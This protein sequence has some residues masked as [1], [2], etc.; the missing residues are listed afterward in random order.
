MT[1]TPALLIPGPTS[2]HLVGQ[3]STI[4]LDHEQASE[5]TGVKLES[6]PDFGW[7]AG[8]YV[9]AETQNQNGHLFHL[10]DVRDRHEQV[11]H[12]A[13]NM[14]HRVHHVLGTFVSSR[15]ILPEGVHAAEALTMPHTQTVAAFWRRR[16]PD[17]W[18]DVME[19]HAQGMAWLSMEAIPESL[20]CVDCNETF[21]YKGPVHESYCDVLRDSIIAP[22][23][24]N[25]P[26]FIGGAAVIP[27]A[28]PGW[29]SADVTHVAAACLAATES[30]AMWKAVTDAA[31]NLGPAELESLMAMLQ[32]L[33]V[34][35]AEAKKR[36]KKWGYG[37]MGDAKVSKKEANYRPS[38]GD[39]QCGNCAHF[40]GNGG[41]G[42]VD[43]TI[44]AT[45]VSDYWTAKPAATAEDQS[46]SPSGANKRFVIVAAIPDEPTAEALA[47]LGTEPAE[48][49]HITLAAI[50][51]LNP[52][53][54]AV[55]PYDIT[56]CMGAIGA[57]A[58]GAPPIDARVSGLGTFVVSEDGDWTAT[59]AS[60]DAPGLNELQSRLLAALR[61]AGISVG[62]DH[63]FTP[64]ITLHYGP[65]GSGPS[66]LPA[67]LQFT[68][69]TL[70]LW[71]GDTHLGYAL[72]NGEVPFY[73]AAR[74]QASLTD[75]EMWALLEGEYGKDYT[76][77]ERRQGAK[78][79]WCMPDGSYP[80]KTKEDLENA[81]ISY[82]RAPKTKRTALKR[83]LA[84]RA[85]A[86]G[87]GQD[88]LQRI[89]EYKT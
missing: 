32:E 73:E 89:S 35:T 30:S 4:T 50:G 38:A 24:L 31:P 1:D 67:Q 48:Q 83:Y 78:A 62:R 60:V 49:L 88:V 18:D 57:F 12:T 16:F 36:V 3:L 68:I 40:D 77:E 51:E 34:G 10:E 19:A 52:E 41:C 58:A 54:D 71:W 7:L 64:H 39:R 44:A 70:E 79:G 17:E 37:P 47:D 13:L 8:R 9:A 26:L 84:R 22:K 55:G 6:R 87:M 85:R 80:T 53:G 43:G 45:Y 76:A 82:G 23:W 20:T 66:E 46:P 42:V 25:K 21:P 15:L 63:G 65:P 81:L 69:D 5:S 2:Y 56:L 75:A 27:P 74:D 11:V 29:K 86:L 33:A 28:R 72:E 59:Y 14:L 61:A